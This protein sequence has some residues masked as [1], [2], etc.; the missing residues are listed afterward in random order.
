MEKDE[1]KENG[2]MLI[3]LYASENDNRW[4]NRAPFSFPLCYETMDVF[5]MREY[6][7]ISQDLKVEVPGVP[8]SRREE[9][10]EKKGQ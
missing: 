7:S 4:T 8:L 5:P 10:M 2:S 1:S 6:R 9:I 3:H